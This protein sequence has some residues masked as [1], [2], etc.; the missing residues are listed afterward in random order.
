MIRSLRLALAALALAPAA[1]VAAAPAA[2][3]AP[4]VD[5]AYDRLFAALEGSQAQRDIAADNT[6][7]A[8]IDG[9]GKALPPIEDAMR[10]NPSMRQEMRDGLLPIV[11]KI[12]DDT[13]PALREAMMPIL[14]KG[15]TRDEAQELGTFYGS[16]LGVR[17]MSAALANYNPQK[18]VAD[19]I[20]GGSI[21]KKAISDDMM[22]AG[23]GAMA[24]LSKED[25]SK[26]IAFAMTPAALKYRTLL[27]ELAAARAVVENAPPSPE[28][29]AEMAEVLYPIF[30][31]YV[32]K[33]GS[34]ATA[35]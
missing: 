11:R 1:V 34:A 31:K 8:I 29:E 13:R 2:I 20:E 6:L 30:N 19:V 24:D 4:A 22:A 16:P 23:M 12:A 9:L 18:T 26:V 32:G 21:G 33:G 15:L 17:L 35:P 25:R 28:L 27:P 10:A 5:P 14:I 3:A 7:D